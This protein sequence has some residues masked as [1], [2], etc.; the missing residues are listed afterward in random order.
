LKIEKKKDDGE[1]ARET[2]YQKKKKKISSHSM[3]VGFSNRFKSNELIRRPAALLL[4]KLG[5]AQAEF[6]FIFQL[7]LLPSSLS[8]F[9]FLLSYFS[10]F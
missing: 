2:R 9:K 7:H 10:L 1:N 4:G 6:T 8:A 3:P 5:S